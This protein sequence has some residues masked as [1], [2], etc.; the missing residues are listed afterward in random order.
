M[1]HPGDLVAQ[2]SVSAPT[3][4]TWTSVPLAGGAVTAGRPYW[5]AVLG[6]GTGTVRFRDKASGSCRAETSRTTGLAALPGTWTTG[7]GY[8]DCPLSGYGT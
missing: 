8:T 7:T 5:I 2:G 1:A 3:A 4:G 6:S